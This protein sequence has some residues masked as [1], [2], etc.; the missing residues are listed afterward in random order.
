MLPNIRMRP[1]YNTL[2]R[3]DGAFMIANLPAHSDLFRASIARSGACN[4]T[5]TPFTFQSERRMLW[6]AP[7]RHRKIVAEHFRNTDCSEDFS[8]TIQT[9]RGWGNSSLAPLQ[10][11][12]W[13]TDSRSC[14]NIRVP[15]NPC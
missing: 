14:E 8:L 11:A 9:S 1:N 7:V 5:L 6:K 15:V 10:Q 12:Y 3:R 13:N 4:R 2:A